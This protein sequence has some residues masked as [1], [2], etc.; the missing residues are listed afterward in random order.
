MEA[1]PPPT[2]SETAAA[3]IG[4]ASPPSYPLD[5]QLH[6]ARRLAASGKAIDA[7]DALRACLWQ[8]GIQS[9][10]DMQASAR[11]ELGDLCLAAGDPITACEHWQIARDYFGELKDEAGM[12]AIETR[13]RSNG[14]PT[15]W[16][17]NDF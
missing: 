15:D 12:A 8:A 5:E 7:A 4:G 2:A 13:M 17:L 3:R 9:R 1:P 11:L 16:V 6:R 10:R 14:C